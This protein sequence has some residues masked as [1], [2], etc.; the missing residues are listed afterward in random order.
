MDTPPPRKGTGILAVTNT[1]TCGDTIQRHTIPFGEGIG[2]KVEP[3]A[4]ACKKCG[5]STN[6]V[7]QIQGPDETHHFE[8]KGVGAE[9]P[10]SLDLRCQ[11]CSVQVASYTFLE[12]E[13]WAIT[14]YVVCRVCGKG[15][16]GEFKA[17]PEQGGANRIF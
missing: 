7:V 13:E 1:C 2:R 14:F 17:K 5:F 15:N 10:Y 4:L 9:K 6:V 12:T 3:I 16:H 8:H 11:S